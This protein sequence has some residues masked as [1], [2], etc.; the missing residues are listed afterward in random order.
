M[1]IMDRCSTTG[2]RRPL[3]LLA[4]L[5]ALLLLATPGASEQQ[6]QHQEEWEQFC[7][8]LVEDYARQHGRDPRPYTDPAKQ[9]VFFLHVPR[10]AGRTFHSCFLKLGT[11][12]SRR[13]PKAYDHLRMNA[14]VPNCQLLSSHDDY[15]VVAMLPDDVAV[16]THLRDPLD[17]FLSA[18]EFAVEVGSRA[19]KRPANFK[20]RAD[21]IATEDV[22]PW[23]Y[24]VPFFAQD[25]KAR[26]RAREGARACH[27]RPRSQHHHRHAA[28]HARA[29]RWPSCCRSLSPRQVQAGTVHQGTAPPGSGGRPGV[30]A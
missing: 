13:C 1:T 9:M 26:V 18:Y 19:Y 17:R 20:K 21:K 11:L 7:S 14:S 6:Q 12:P 8:A 30:R 24:L 4:F 5:A 28:A 25:I 16:L 15:S 3:S 23:S 2:R 29:R 27:H 22:W 10:T